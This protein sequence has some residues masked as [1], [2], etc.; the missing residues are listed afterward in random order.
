MRRKLLLLGD[1]GALY[2]ALLFT[3]LTRYGHGAE[4]WRELQ[5]HWLPFS[6]IF[7]SWLVVFYAANLYEIGLAKNN[8]TFYTAYFYSLAFASLLAIA[9]FYFVPYFRIA[10]R[11]NL[12]LFLLI[13]L[14]LTIP[15][16]LCFNRLVARG[17]NRNNLL[18]VGLSEQ[19]QELYDFLLA[20]RQLGYRPLGI[21]DVA[22]AQAP[23]T[24]KGV[25]EKKHVRILILDP[26]A[27]RILQIIDTLYGFLKYKMTYHE[28]S[29]FYE[30]VT[31]KV[32]VRAIDQTWFFE[33]L[34]EGAKRGYEIAKR[35]WDLAG[36]LLLG[37][38]V[39]PFFPL[40]ALAIRLDSSGPVFYRQRRVGRVGRVFTLVKFRNMLNNAESRT[41]PVWAAEDDARTTRVGRFL[42]RTRLDELPQLW[43]IL[44]GEMSFIGPRP[45]RPEFHDKL[46]AQI[47]FY[48]E[49][50]LVR[51]GLTGW[52]Q[53]K[54]RLDFRGGLTVGDT[55]EKLQY[56]L[57]YIK[58]RSPLLDLGIA[59]KTGAIILQKFF[60]KL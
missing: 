36:S 54:Y 55:M 52:A 48:D 11:T 35:A 33:N 45:E 37:L 30:Q 57:Y 8:L 59:L 12:F 49:R 41:G 42:R 47:P 5:L 29:G 17:S 9:F 14:A 56:D 28:L 32:P 3:L 22:H 18:I 20:N 40:I 38:L 16:R 19:S 27:Y 39:L 15:W 34:S 43:N 2:L 44:K 53:V 58:N 24:L 13:Q 4:F 51:P 31:G 26:A 1:A 46:K 7:A 50:Y 25:V 23:Y 6:I 21:V 10:P 60:S